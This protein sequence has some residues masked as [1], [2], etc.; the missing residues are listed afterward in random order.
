[1]SK[2]L[3]AIFLLLLTAFCCTSCFIKSCQEK[4]IQKLEFEISELKSEI[5]PMAFQITKKDN[6][7]MFVSVKF[8]DEDR[9]ER[10]GA[11][12]IFVPGKELHVY[13]KVAE[14]KNSF[15]FFPI[16][17]YSEKIPQENSIKIYQYYTHTEN[18]I[19]YPKIYY[20]AFTDK[21]GTELSMECKE[22][23]KAFSEALNPGDGIKSWGSTV[24]DLSQIKQFKVNTIYNVVCHP[25]LKG[26][27][28]EITE[29]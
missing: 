27:G 21:D 14:I 29:R 5:I 16:S 11:K 2:I 23:E 15:V 26:G 17:L 7:G 1:M 8:Y 24:H 10:G 9:N 4:K 22:I 13:S 25:H 19:S 20:K 6:K 3:T 18:G 28:I 12:D